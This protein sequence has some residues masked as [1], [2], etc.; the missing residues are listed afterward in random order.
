[1]TSE[2]RVFNMTEVNSRA[3]RSPSGFPSS[4][5]QAR[6]DLNE[7]PAK[8]GVAYGGQEHQGT[9]TGSTCWCSEATD[10]GSRE[11]STRDPGPS[12]PMCGLLPARLV[13]QLRPSWQ[14]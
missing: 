5:L 14:P 10:R 8:R 12:V 9:A 3:Q 4:A 6:K 13:I 7:L 2:T 1:M 11:Q